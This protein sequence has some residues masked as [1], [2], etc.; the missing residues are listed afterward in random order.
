MEPQISEQGKGQH[1]RACTRAAYISPVEQSF[2]A[3]TCGPAQCDERVKGEIDLWVI[4]LSPFGVKFRHESSLSKGESEIANYQAGCSLEGLISGQRCLA[5]EIT[6]SVVMNGAKEL[7][8]YRAGWIQGPKHKVA[9]V[10]LLVA[11]VSGVHNGDA[12]WRQVN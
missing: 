10:R 2:L 1:A 11:S 5:E 4:V 7:L 8:G 9:E 12:T 3:F 6:A